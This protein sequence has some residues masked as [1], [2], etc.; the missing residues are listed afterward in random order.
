MPRT[1]AADTVGCDIGGSDVKLLLLRGGR[2]SR[3]QSVPCPAD[4]GKKEFTDRLVSLLRTFPANAAGIALPGFLDEKRRRI[5]HLSNLP[6]LDGLDLAARLERRLKWKIILEA[7]SNAGAIGE[8]R[9]GAG[10]GIRRLLYLTMGTG[11]GAALTVKGIPVRVSNNTIGHIAGLPIG[12]AKKREAEKLLGARGIL[13]RFRAAG[14]DRRVSTPLA[15]CELALSGDVGARAAWKETGELLAELLA[16]LVPMLRPDGVVLGGGIA[17][18]ADTFL[19]TTLRALRRRLRGSEPGCP[20]IFPAA[21]KAYA[22]AAGAALS[23][24]SPLS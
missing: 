6:K 19:P 16:I 1:G 8:A 9:L 7:D 10:R 20:E 24:R 23:A 11:L 12:P 2:P 15:L 3:M 13:R 22:G 4:R 21:L 17:G 5:L 18:A 14:G